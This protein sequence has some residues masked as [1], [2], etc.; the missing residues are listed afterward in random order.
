MDEMLNR[1]VPHSLEA[2][3]AVLGAMLIDP[4]CVPDVVE[5]LNPSD[6]YIDENRVIFETIYSM[7]AT[8]G[9]KVDPVT[10]IEELKVSGQYENSGGSAYLMQLMDVT[11]TAA[12]VKEYCE[13]VRGKSMLR[14]VLNAS[15]ET[16]DLILSEEG[17]PADIADLAEQKIYAI[18]QG[19]EVKGLTHIK[20]AISDVYN[21]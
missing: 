12:N 6:F 19:R 11:P 8:S 13:I 14:A 17:Q 21:T 7:F 9:K 5:I 10:V 15:S 1:K 2:E 4:V 20:T 3:Q 18:R 16:V